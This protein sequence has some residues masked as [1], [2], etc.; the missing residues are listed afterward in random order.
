M[1]Q[2]TICPSQGL[3]TAEHGAPRWQGRSCHLCKRAVPAPLVERLVPGR[4]QP[5]EARRDPVSKL[6]QDRPPAFSGAY[7]VQVLT[8]GLQRAHG[9]PLVSLAAVG[10]C[11]ALEAPFLDLSPKRNLTQVMAWGSTTKELHYA[12]TLRANCDVK[13]TVG[14]GGQGW[15]AGENS[16]DAGARVGVMESR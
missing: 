16:R 6:E 10:M 14:L 12:W 9:S 13:A 1:F 8:W 7:G 4:P 15:G 11:L 5:T 3:R 2:G